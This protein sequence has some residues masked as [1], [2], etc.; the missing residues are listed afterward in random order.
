MIKHLW[1]LKNRST[2]GQKA[3]GDKEALKSAGEFFID[4][5]QGANELE[6]LNMAT[7][8]SRPVDFA[9]LDGGMQIF[10]GGPDQD[11]DGIDDDCDW[12][13]ADENNDGEQ[14]DAQ[15]RDGQGADG[16][17]ATYNYDIGSFGWTNLDRWY[18]FAGA[19]TEIFI[20]VPD[21]I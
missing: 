20:D 1:L 2:L 5:K 7:V 10:R 8:Q 4:A 17:F 15:I 13:A 18:N 16:A 21:G 9:D 3:N 12:V 6:L 14:D 11:C 19:K